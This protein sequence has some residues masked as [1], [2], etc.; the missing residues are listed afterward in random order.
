MLLTT[1]KFN[2]VVWSNWNFRTKIGL[3]TK[4]GTQ[5]HSTY[6]KQPLYFKDQ[7][8][9]SLDAL[10][11][12][13]SSSSASKQAIICKARS[14]LEYVP[15]FLPVQQMCHEPKFLFFSLSLLLMRQKG[16][17]AFL[18]SSLKWLSLPFLAYIG[19]YPSRCKQSC[20]LQL[21]YIYLEGQT[22]HNKGL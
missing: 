9:H 7:W 4:C 15:C 5:H 2:S 11:K 6:S 14:N 16:S 3:L 19:P 13:R 17:G 22:A 18:E 1:V 12:R 10:K 20:I 21:Y 8:L